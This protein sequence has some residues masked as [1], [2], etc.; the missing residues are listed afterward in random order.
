M[1]VIEKTVMIPI[2]LANVQNIQQHRPNHRV[3]T[4][5]SE[6]VADHHRPDV[7]IKSPQDDAVQAAVVT[8]VVIHVTLIERES[9]HAANGHRP[10]IVQADQVKAATN[11]INTHV[12][13]ATPE[14]IAI[15]EADIE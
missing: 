11:M 7:N 14:V 5:V 4:I 1:K 2:R 8:V 15:K 9:I 3:V 12:K 13:K 6:I 10:M